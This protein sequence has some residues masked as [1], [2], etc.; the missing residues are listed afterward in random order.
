MGDEGAIGDRTTASG[1]RVVEKMCVLVGLV[2]TCVESS[3]HRWRITHERLTSR[4]WR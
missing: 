1:I 3:L 4:K 2:I